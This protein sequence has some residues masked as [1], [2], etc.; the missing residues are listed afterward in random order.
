[1]LSDVFVSAEL[2]VSDEAWR[3]RESLMVARAGSS[4]RVTTGL[5]IALLGNAQAERRNLVVGLAQEA[6][7][8]HRPMEVTTW[9]TAC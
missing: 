8:P 7:Q 9:P 2:S 4:N 1:V 5:A 3:G 6:L